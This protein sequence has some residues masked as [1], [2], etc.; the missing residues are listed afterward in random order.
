MSIRDEIQLLRH[1]RDWRGRSTVPR[2]ADPYVLD[3]GE[4]EFPTGWARTKAGKLARSVLQRGLLKPVTWSQT[5]PF[6]LGGR[7]A[8]FVSDQH[9]RRLDEVRARYDPEGRF[10][11]WMGR[12]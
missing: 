2:S 8:R 4:R 1:G 7:P 5:R 9:L 12:P 10:H 3:D 6:V 11:S